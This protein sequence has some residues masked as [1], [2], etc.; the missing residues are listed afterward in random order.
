MIIIFIGINMEFK[1]DSLVFDASTTFKINKVISSS[2]FGMNILCNNLT[3]IYN[4][5]IYPVIGGTRKDFE[6][7]SFDINPGIIGFELE[8][9]VLKKHGWIFG[10]NNSKGKLGT[11]ERGAATIEVGRFDQG[12]PSYQEAK[13]LFGLYSDDPE[14]VLTAI[15]MLLGNEGI[16]NV[17]ADYGGQERISPQK[18]LDTLKL[19]EWQKILENFYQLK[20]EY[21]KALVDIFVEPDQYIHNMKGGETLKDLFKRKILE[22]QKESISDSN[23]DGSV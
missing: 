19:E 21:V 16:Q 14:Y 9:I 12:H 20:K 7:D 3:S 11:I 15:H 22:K 10:N 23:R 5:K 17:F 6:L 2:S 1:L 8:H 4:V 13:E 18:M